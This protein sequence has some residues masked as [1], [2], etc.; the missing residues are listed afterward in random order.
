MTRTPPVASPTH[1]TLRN[2][3]EGETCPV[4]PDCEGTLESGTYKG[5]FALVC[6]VCGTPTT[7][8]WAE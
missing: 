8:V 4:I 5:T 2:V 7:R 1:E 3:L 6:D